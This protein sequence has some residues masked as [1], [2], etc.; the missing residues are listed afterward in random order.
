MNAEPIER[1]NVSKLA[2]DIRNPR[3]P[4]FDLTGRHAGGGRRPP[5]VGNNGRAGTCDVHCR[6]RF[7]F[8]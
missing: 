7:L 2:F 1:I 5:V 3:L 8:S 6:E 4:E